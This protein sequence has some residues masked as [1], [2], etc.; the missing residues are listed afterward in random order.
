M[1]CNVPRQAGATYKS[2]WTRARK[3][4]ELRRA[5]VTKKRYKGLDQ[6]PIYVSPTL[7]YNNRRDY[8]LKAQQ[9]VSILTLSGRVIIP[10]S[11]YTKHLALIGHGV[12]IG[13]AR[14]WYDQSRKRFYLPVSLAIELADP[15]FDQ[16]KH[17]VGVDV[18]IRYLAATSTSTGDPAFF[19][20]KMP[21]TK[22]PKRHACNSLPSCG[23]V[24]SASPRVHSWGH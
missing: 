16:Y 17:L 7:T 11:G 3:H 10:S 2:L 5:G 14:L 20:G 6:P 22:K 19:A 12:G 8:T 9:Q 13:A 23:G 1:A 15:S 4:A 18:G 21:P 24:E